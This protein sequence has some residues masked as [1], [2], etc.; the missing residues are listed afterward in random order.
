MEAVLS[1]TMRQCG[2]ACDGSQLRRVAQPDASNKTCTGRRKA[3][4]ARGSPP[5]A[6]SPS[7][8]SYQGRYW[9]IPTLTRCVNGLTV[10][11]MLFTLPFSAAVAA[12]VLSAAA[13]VLFPLA[14][15]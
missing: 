2:H 6:Q 12:A 7:C 9:Q 8:S 4:R 11:S 15:W 3:E 10:R 13:V 1:G 5:L 14:V